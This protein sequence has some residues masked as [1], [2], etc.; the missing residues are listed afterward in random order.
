MI[1]LVLTN[2]NRNLNTVK[3]CLDSLMKQSNTDFELFFVDY[4]SNCDYVVNLEKLLVEYPT[5][6]YINCPVSGQLWNKSRAINIALQK[7]KTRNFLV[8]DIDMIY[9]DD[10]IEKAIKISDKNQ[11]TYFKVG[12]L[13]K[14]E[15]EKKLDFNDFNIKHFSTAEAT[16]IT[17]FSTQLLKT[18]NGYDEFYHGWG[19]E[20]AD[21]HSRI[22]NAGEEI[23]FYK[24]EVLVKHQWHAKTYRSKESLQPFHSELELIN[25]DYY[26]Q[27]NR[28]RRTKANKKVGYGREV[29]HSEYCKLHQKADFFLQCINS[30]VAFQ[31]LLAQLANFSQETVQVV[32]TKVS[33]FKLLKNKIKHFI[34]KKNIDY[35][36]MN[37]INNAIL[38][39]IIKNYR[40]NPYQY[41]FDRQKNLITLTIRF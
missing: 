30:E 4:G 25:H 17:L 15:S 8:G 41:T 22:K 16:G 11:T 2:R 5:I 35:L 10:F 7:C 6:N 40:N 31:A 32:V 1:T 28:N 33:F 38:I 36:S 37:T 34:G 9:R 19:A 39:E 18:L 24:N 14:R 3:I 12:F 29:L 13:D 26:D 21:I 23:Y 27:S 20:D